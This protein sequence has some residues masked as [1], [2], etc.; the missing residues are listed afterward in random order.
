MFYKGRHLHLHPHTLYQ[1]LLLHQIL[2]KGLYRWNICHQTFN[3]I[4]THRESKG[5]NHGHSI[6]S[7]TDWSI[8]NCTVHPLKMAFP[9][10]TQYVTCAHHQKMIEIVGK[11]S[12]VHSHEVGLFEL[13]TAL[14]TPN[15]QKQ[16]VRGQVMDQTIH[17]VHPYLILLWR[18][19][20]RLQ[21]ERWEQQRREE[22]RMQ[23]YELRDML[24]KGLNCMYLHN[25][26]GTPDE[27]YEQ[28][29]SEPLD[30]WAINQLL[31]QSTPL[32][33][34]DIEDAIP[35]PCDSSCGTVTIGQKWDAIHRGLKSYVSMSFSPP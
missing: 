30:N 12:I 22:Q 8:P 17:Q 23:E 16:I 33:Q 15:V 14:E 26:G 5:H 2:S 35:T 31:R 10:T 21:K 7:S 18:T 13:M 20:W 24:R 3:I 25:L 29:K 28:I 9:F 4:N 32:P 6:W 34:Y 11:D 27:T 19:R 1:I